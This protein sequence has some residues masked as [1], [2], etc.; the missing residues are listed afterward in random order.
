MDFLPIQVPAECSREFPVLHSRLSLFIY[1]IY[2]IYRAHGSIPI[3]QLL[4]PS[5][6]LLGF[7]IA[8]EGVEKRG[9]S[10]TVGGGVN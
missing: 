3:S 8:G 6:A 10:R 1:F 7:H 5:P 2:R 9:S 4:P